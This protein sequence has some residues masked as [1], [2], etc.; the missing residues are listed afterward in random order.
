MVTSLL[1][2]LLHRHL[3]RI[4]S[5]CLLGT[6]TR[7]KQ[8]EEPPYRNPSPPDTPILYPKMSHSPRRSFKGKGHRY[9]V[10]SLGLLQVSRSRLLLMLWCPANTTIP[11]LDPT[12]TPRFLPFTPPRQVEM[13]LQQCTH[14]DHVQFRKK[15]QAGSSSSAP[16]ENAISSNGSLSS[17]E[18]ET[19]LG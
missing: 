7:L 2:L 14:D 13:L 12:T 10:G 9:S 18:E 11:R 8:E 17:H 19:E 16:S 15:T 4:R 6:L 1:F 5:R 3:R